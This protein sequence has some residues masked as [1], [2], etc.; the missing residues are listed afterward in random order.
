MYSTAFIAPSYMES[1]TGFS[2]AP[3]PPSSNS[4]SPHL[5]IEAL[6]SVAYPVASTCY[7]L[8]HRSTSKG[9]NL[10]DYITNNKPL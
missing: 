3:S 2:Q 9:R 6:P 10:K 8:G 1:L 5:T 7:P 4:V